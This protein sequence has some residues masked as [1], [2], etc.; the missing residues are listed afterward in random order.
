VEEDVVDVEEE[1]KEAEE[2][3]K[4]LVTI[5]PF[6]SAWFPTLVKIFISQAQLL[7]QMHEHAPSLTS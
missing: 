6:I 1:E 3:V 4:P 7:I 2:E 5:S